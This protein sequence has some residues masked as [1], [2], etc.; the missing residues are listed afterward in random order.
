M[1]TTPFLKLSCNLVN[2]STSCGWDRV[3]TTSLG[4]EQLDRKI[5]SYFFHKSFVTHMEIFFM[6]IVTEVTLSVLTAFIKHVFLKKEET[7]PFNIS[8]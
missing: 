4:T 5:T 2:S 6:G 8:I 3:E 7:S 1:L